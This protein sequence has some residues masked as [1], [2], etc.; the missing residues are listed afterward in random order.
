MK[1]LYSDYKRTEGTMKV[2]AVYRFSDLINFFSDYI[3]SVI[4]DGEV[5]HG[6]REVTHGEVSGNLISLLEVVN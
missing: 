3:K 5:F 1:K 2:R 6:E 4:S